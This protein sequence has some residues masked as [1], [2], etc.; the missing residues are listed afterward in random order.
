MPLFLADSGMIYTP[1]ARHIWD[2]LLGTTPKI[3]SFLGAEASQEAYNRLQQTAEEQGRPIYE[4][5]LQEHHASITREREKTDYAFAARR[6]T[7]A[8]IGLPQVRNHRL[9]LLAQEERNVRE[10][11][12]RRAQI[13][14]E[15]APLILIRVE[16]N[17]HE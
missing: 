11:L 3:H 10:Q 15:M 14:P 16:G 7:I 6:R 9:S 13:Y 8:R 12:D 17:S 4:A 1:T 5:L 2:Q